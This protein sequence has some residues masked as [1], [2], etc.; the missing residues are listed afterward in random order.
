MLTEERY[1]SPRDLARAIGVSESSVKR[2]IDAGRIAA[3]RTHGGHRRIALEA[4]LAFVRDNALTL[5]EPARLGLAAVAATTPTRLDCADAEPLQSL[6]HDGDAHQARSLILGLYLAGWSVARIVDGPLQRAM[7]ALGALWQHGPEGIFIEHRA[8]A[9]VL[10]I[11]SELRPLA[12]RSTLHAPLALGSAGPDDGHALPSLAASVA[13]AEVGWRAI[14]LGAALPLAALRVAIER[15]EPRLLWL[16]LSTLDHPHALAS[17]LCDLLAG[18]RCPPALAIG[19][20]AAPR[21]ELPS[22]LT[23]FRGQSMGE[24]AAFARGVAA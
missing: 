7:A 22:H 1:L 21:L 17:E 10:H 12:D 14:D 9:I 8:T 11:L 6:L 5:A 23:V 4:A 20:L 16:S 13:L 2:W 18:L 24:L 19:G 15:L 3:L